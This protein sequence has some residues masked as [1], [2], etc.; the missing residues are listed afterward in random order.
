VLVAA[1]TEADLGSV[2]AAVG[3]GKTGMAV[4]GAADVNVVTSDTRAYVTGKKTSGIDAGGT[5]AVVADD[6]SDFSLWAGNGA[7]SWE[8]SAAIGVAATVL[9][10]HSSTLAYIDGAAQVAGHGN[11]TG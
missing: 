10:H 9:V 7:F 3:A 5:L 2:A 1:A 4:A 11:G 6:T 8:G